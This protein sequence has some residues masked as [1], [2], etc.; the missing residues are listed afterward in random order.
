HGREVSCVARRPGSS[1]GRV[2]CVESDGRRPRADRHVRDGR[3]DRMPQPL[4]GR[5]VLRAAAERAHAAEEEAESLLQGTRHAVEPGL[6]LDRMDKLLAD[7]ANALHRR[8]LLSLPRV[9]RWSSP[10]TAQSSW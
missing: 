6:L 2:H 1:G 9:M 5:D 4:P 10:R 3:M 7:I 8:I